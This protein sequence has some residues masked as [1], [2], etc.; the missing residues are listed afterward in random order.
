MLI[1]RDNPVLLAREFLRMSNQM[2]A[3][4]HA[5]NGCYS[6]HVLAFKRLDALEAELDHAPRQLATRLRAVFTAPPPQAADVL[7]H[8]IEETYDVIEAQLP[9]VDVTRLRTRFHADRK[10]V[11]PRTGGG[12]RGPHHLGELDA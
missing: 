10:P 1:E 4:L 9:E 3:V 5:V 2:L 7:R 12:A 11:E 8:L 6:G